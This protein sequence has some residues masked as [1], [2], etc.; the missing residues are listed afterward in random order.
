MRVDADD[1]LSMNACAF[2]GSV[3][4]NNDDIG[5]V[6][7]DHIRLANGGASKLRVHS[8]MKRHCLNMALECCSEQKFLDHLVAMTRVYSIVKIEICYTE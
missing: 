8:P 4:D 1:Y 7:G 2:M 3:L 5:F 6:Y